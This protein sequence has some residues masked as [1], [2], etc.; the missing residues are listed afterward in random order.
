MAQDNTLP[1]SQNLPFVEQLQI[2]D[3]ERRVLVLG[4]S[5]KRF[6]RFGDGGG[7][8]ITHINMTVNTVRQ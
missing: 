6:L 7:I 1:Y 5:L 2:T 8:V 4:R 3:L